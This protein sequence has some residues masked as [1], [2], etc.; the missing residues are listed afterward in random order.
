MIADE[1]DALTAPE[2]AI[3]AGTGHEST[4]IVRRYIRERS[5]F[6]ESA[7]GHLLVDL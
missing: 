6:M 3:M 1:M 5:E 2:R 4:A 7:S